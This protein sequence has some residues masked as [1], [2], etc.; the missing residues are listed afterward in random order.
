LPLPA[1]AHGN[2]A[3]IGGFYGGLLHP[4]LVP[5]EFLTVI[6]TGLL[7]GTTGREACR[8]G[9]IAFAAGV[10]AG[11]AAARY[12]GPSVELTT[13]VSLVMGLVAGLAVAAGIRVATALAFLVAAAAGVAIGMDAAPEESTFPTHLVASIATVLGSTVLLLLTA[14]LALGRN[15]HWQRIA[16]RIAGSWVAAC[17]ILYFAWELRVLLAS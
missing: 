11:L 13:S 2:V 4:L 3:G 7:L 8:L 17:S 15:I 5:A 9:L 10:A 16:V 12:L 14:V 6:A 1:Q